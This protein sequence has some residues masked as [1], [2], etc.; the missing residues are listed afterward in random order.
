MHNQ[1]L[2]PIS[3]TPRDG[4][5]HLIPN[6][7]C[8]KNQNEYLISNSPKYANVSNGSLFPSLSSIQPEV[9]LTALAKSANVTS[10]KPSWRFEERGKRH[11]LDLDPP[12]RFRRRGATNDCAWKKSRGIKVGK[13]DGKR[14]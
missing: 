4:T 11:T 12:A 13:D 3:T 5:T 1:P 9:K 10:R 8:R 6:L 2:S 14:R 7:V